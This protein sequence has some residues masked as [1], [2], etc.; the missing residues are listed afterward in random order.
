MVGPYL[1]EDILDGNTNSTIMLN[2][3]NILTPDDIELIKP[4]S[5]IAV[6]T[7]VIGATFLFLFIF[8]RD[9]TDHPSRNAP[10]VEES[11]DGKRVEVIRNVKP[12]MR[13]FVIFLA[14]FFMVFYI[15]LEKTVGT[16]IQAFG[17]DGQLKLPKQLGALMSA[18]YWTA[19]TT[20]RLCAVFLADIFG[21][22]PVLIFNITT[23]ITGT[24]CICTCQS[25]ELGLWASFVLI[26]IGLSSTWGSMF[27]FMES[28]F[29]LNG[30]IVSC[31]T[32]GASIGSSVVP[33][34]IGLLM[35]NNNET[36]AWFCLL[37]SLLIALMFIIIF[38]ICRTVLFTE[39]RR[40][41]KS[42][43]SII[44]QPKY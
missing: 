35:A 41:F 30:K 7:A 9:T 3:T 44:S 43:I 24:I 1:K 38:V 27:G 32:V 21:S 18:V 6:I 25:S 42:S 22:L 12:R 28:Q 13:I 14:S 36:F 5:M 34:V 2:G 29:P 39:E 31:F 4:Y 8:S 16:F 19:F 15:G 26:G 17:H 37:L 20:F 11:K 33:A 23:T 40:R 10:V